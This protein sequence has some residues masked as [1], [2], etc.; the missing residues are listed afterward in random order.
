M[1]RWPSTSPIPGSDS[2][3]SSVAVFR[4]TSCPASPPEPVEPVP[5]VTPE[6]DAPGP[7]APRR[8]TMTCSPSVRRAARLMLWRSAFGLAPPALSMASITRSPWWNRNTP[9]W[10][11]HPA[12]STTISA[13]EGVGAGMG[14]GPGTGPAEND[15]V[16]VVSVG[17]NRYGHPVPAVLAEL[18]RDG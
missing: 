14:P 10:R 2:S 13:G 4:L 1:I 17:P 11:T 6:L 3:S 18:A 7:D 8:P 16:A 12:T 5:D 15:R 9:G